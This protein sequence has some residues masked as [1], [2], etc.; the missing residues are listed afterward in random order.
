MNLYELDQNYKNLMEVMDN[1]ETENNEEL[2]NIITNSL[3]ELQM[4]IDLKLENTIKYIK[5]LEANVLAFK[6]EEKKL[7]A[8]RKV[9]E[10]RVSSLKEYLKNYLQY[11]DIKSKQLGLFKISLRKSESVNIIDETLIKEEYK[12]IKTDVNKTL[13]KQAL[14]SGEIIEGAEIKQNQNL[15]IK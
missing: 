13:I 10:N 2:K 3:E 5:N 14:K 8:K 1:A 9:L 7:S 4:D 15:N 11:K 6:D 12:I